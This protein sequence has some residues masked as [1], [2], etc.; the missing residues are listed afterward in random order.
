M[1]SAPHPLA[2]MTRGASRDKPGKSGKHERP[3]PMKRSSP[4]RVLETTDARSK[5][6]S[7]I[8][9]SGT[10]PELIV[11]STLRSI[12]VRFSTNTRGLSGSPDIA[13]KSRRFAIFVHGC[14][15]H[16]H[17]RCRLAT[18]PR[19][20]QTFWIA[21]FEANVQRDRRNRSELRRA[22]YKVLVIWQCQTRAPERLRDRLRRFIESSDHR[23]GGKL[24][25]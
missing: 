18:T 2:S 23:T 3:I 9:Q 10:D 16:R 24:K 15:W 13:N 5:L 21:K 14:F 25:P 12:G 19:R 4:D 7:R 6:M 20:N 11:R 17:R 8:R 1:A 22:G